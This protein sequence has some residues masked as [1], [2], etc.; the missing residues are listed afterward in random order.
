MIGPQ[1]SFILIID[2]STK[3]KESQNLGFFNEL[4]VQD[5]YNTDLQ[6]Q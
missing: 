3:V 2:D 4:Y 6:C 5:I 1:K